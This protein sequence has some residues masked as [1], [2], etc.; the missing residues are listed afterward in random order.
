MSFVLATS[1]LASV[2]ITSLM[3]YSNGLRFS[4]IASLREGPSA[5]SLAREVVANARMARSVSQAPSLRTLYSLRLTF[6]NDIVIDNA[7]IEN[8]M[9]REDSSPR[10]NSLAASGGGIRWTWDWFA[11]PLP[12]PG[13]I[14]FEIRWPLLELMES[15]QIEFGDQIRSAALRSLRLSR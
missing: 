10:L 4:V 8:G 12:T 1:P 14:T 3:A 11:T 9:E 13:P 15:Q 6:A 2:G 5:A 7:R